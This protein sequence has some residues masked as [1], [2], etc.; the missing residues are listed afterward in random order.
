VF[1]QCLSEVNYVRLTDAFSHYGL[2]P[3]E[4]CCHHHAA[5]EARSQAA[6]S[7]CRYGR[8]PRDQEIE[9]PLDEQSHRYGADGLPDT[10]RNE[11]AEQ[12]CT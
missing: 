10:D 4:Q 2:L 1:E 8:G 11:P 9:A 3:P 6:G 5:D 7:Q 12:R